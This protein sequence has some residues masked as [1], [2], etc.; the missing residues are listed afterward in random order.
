M[1]DWKE[2]GRIV[3][4]K[5]GYD[6][7]SRM[8]EDGKYPILS[9]AGITGYHNEYKAEGEG[10]VTGRYGTLGEMYYVNG[11]YWP[12]NTAL[13][14][15]DFKGNYPKYVY[16]LLKSLN[17][18]SQSDKS[19]VPGINRNDLH[20]LKVP[21]VERKYQI[22]IA[23]VLSSLDA[24]IEINNR[25]NAELEAMAKTLYDYWFVQFDFPD[26][27][28]RPYK[29]NGGQMVWDDELKRKIPEGWEVK[30]LADWVLTDKS[31]DW[32]QEE[33]QGNYIQKVTCIRGADINGLNGL[34]M[35]KPP[36]RYI[37]EKNSYKILNSHDLVVE[38]S[39]GSPTQ[40]TGRLAYIT[41][42]TLRR[43]ETPLICSNFCKAVVLKDK[44]MLYNFV[45]YW[46][47]LYD[48]GVFFGYEGKTS[49]IKNFLFDSFV[50]SYYTVVP[51]GTLID[52]FYDVI[53]NIQI[54][55]Q[56]ALA[57][58]QRLSS[59]RDWLLPMLMNGQ[60]TVSSMK[61]NEEH[62]FEVEKREAL[63]IADNKKAFAKQVLGGKIVSLFQSDPYFTNIK[64][65]KIQY[66]A[67]HVAE[68]DLN[69][70]YY[71]QAAGPYDNVYMH[72]IS[73][74]FKTSN[75]FA[76]E[77]HKYRPLE[78]QGQIDGYYQSFFQPVVNRLDNLFTL[79][80]DVTDIE[81]EIIATLYAVWNNRI[82]LNQPV[83]EELLIEDFYNWSDR[84][85]LYTPEQL[86]KGLQWLHTNNI[87][88][89]GFGKE[90]KRA[91]EKVK[92]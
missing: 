83:A 31:G 60:V 19:A 91:K 15:T 75:W 61:Q 74:K 4:F 2:I 67:E 78:K 70:N 76:R 16:Y 21:Y 27:D 22:P 57:E 47:S 53:K 62:A 54:K 79:L 26:T 72:T 39:G 85:L 11:R 42:A 17:S 44:K 71:Y 37:L 92:Q 48:S 65:Q 20:E 51:E 5:R 33:P 46:N 25:I 59:L 38:I 45:Y 40:S 50:N 58:N 77:E 18:L 68:V 49:G 12:H 30:K 82:I 81:A 28:G 66:L 32:G 34:G 86:Q 64:F 23:S 1:S 88:P 56:T 9:S 84:K 10:L 3:N 13:Y 69:W 55:K 41:E 8:R 14:V 63:F 7:P 90:M 89:N 52:K 43:F 35:L 80:A 29:T 87:V 24:K 36:V 6:L 73:D